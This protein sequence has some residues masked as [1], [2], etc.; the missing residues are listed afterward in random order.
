MTFPTDVEIDDD[1]ANRLS[2]L[3]RELLESERQSIVG[4]DDARREELRGLIEE[5]EAVLN[6]E[7]ELVQQFDEY[8]ATLSPRPNRIRELQMYGDWEGTLKAEL[9]SWRDEVNALE[10]REVDKQAIFDSARNKAMHLLR[11]AAE[12]VELLPD[13]AGGNEALSATHFGQQPALGNSSPST[14]HTPTN[15]AVLPV[16]LVPAPEASFK[17]ALMR[18]KQAWIVTTYQDGRE[19]VSLWRA[20]NI[21]PS[22]NIVG[23]IRSRPQFRSGT[24][25]AH[26]IRSVRVSIDHPETAQPPES[27][28]TQNSVVP[29]NQ[30]SGGAAQISISDLRGMKSMADLKPKSI[31]FPDGTKE[32]ITDWRRLYVTVADWLIDSGRLSQQNIPNKVQSHFSDEQVQ[33]DSGAFKSRKLKNGMWLNTNFSAPQTMSRIGQLLEAFGENPAQFQVQ[34]R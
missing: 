29:A 9:A 20:N 27:E 21:T 28:G 2:V 31:S 7:G 5:R 8:I 1:L 22:S 25:Q 10:S 16:T 13:H 6:D 11:R 14:L 15:S 26:G 19:D 17:D 24:W 34:L 4:A 33:F 23:N 3:F 18:T 32:S 30:I 12:G